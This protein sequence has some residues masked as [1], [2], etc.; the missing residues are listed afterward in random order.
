MKNV[1]SWSVN[2]WVRGSLLA[3][4]LGVA[5]LG[6]GF[7]TLP[8]AESEAA[9]GVQA[10]ARVLLLRGPIEEVFVVREVRGAHARV[11]LDLDWARGEEDHPLLTGL[12]EK[13]EE[14]LENL[15]RDEIEGLI[16]RL[17]N[18][19]EGLKSKTERSAEERVAVTRDNALW[20]NFAA[21]ERYLVLK[22]AGGSGAEGEKPR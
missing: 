16:E 2:E 22:P 6:L 8:A 17:R 18:A 19:Q 21:V 3:S 20:V 5:A 1:K 12:L 7:A 4:L 9:P 11:E 15:D 10:G 14:A 13:S